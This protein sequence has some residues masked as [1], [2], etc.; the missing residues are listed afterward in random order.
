MLGVTHPTKVG[1]DFNA[2]LLSGLSKQAA[3]RMGHH[4]S[5]DG[6]LGRRTR[7]FSHEVDALSKR[8]WEPFSRRRIKSLLQVAVTPTAARLERM[9]VM[10]KDSNPA[11]ATSQSLYQLYDYEK[12]ATSLCQASETNADTNEGF[13]LFLNPCTPISRL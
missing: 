5:S 4:Q 10:S 1:A 8:L 12:H 6:Q 3:E 7:S 11:A 13:L 9:G 2:L